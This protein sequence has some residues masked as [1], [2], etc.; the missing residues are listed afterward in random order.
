MRRR[1]IVAVL[2][3]TSGVEAGREHLDLE[4]GAK[5]DADGACVTPSSLSRRAPR[6][7]GYR[8]AAQP[9]LTCI[10]PVVAA[11]RAPEPR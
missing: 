1:G 6:Q 7:P 10:H 11:F 4:G 3:A 2:V 5:P 8:V 9:C